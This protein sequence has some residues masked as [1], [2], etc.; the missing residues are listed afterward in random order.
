M[1]NLNTVLSKCLYDA[2]NHYTD[3]L[4]QK[5][6]HGYTLRIVESSKTMHEELEMDLSEND[7][8]KV[9]RNL[10]EMIGNTWLD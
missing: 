1:K 6:K 7:I 5:T 10:Q 2:D 9:I 8:R 3:L 4:C